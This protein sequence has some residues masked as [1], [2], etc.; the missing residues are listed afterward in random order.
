MNTTHAATT[1]WITPQPRP[2]HWSRADREYAAQHTPDSPPLPAMQ[3]HATAGGP[4]WR[5]QPLCGTCHMEPD[6]R[7][8]NGRR[9]HTSVG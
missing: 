2:L 6:A 8:Y 7:D 1:T 9:V 3:H 5:G 4:E